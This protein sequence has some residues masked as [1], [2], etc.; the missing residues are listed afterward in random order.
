[1]IR[2][3]VLVD[4]VK[5][6]GGTIVLLLFVD[7]PPAIE[8]ELPQTAEWLIEAIRQRKPE[9]VNEL[10]RRYMKAAVLSERIQ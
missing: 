1:M 2:P 3:E 7:R 5:K 4:E 10:K 9:I 8:L 6:L